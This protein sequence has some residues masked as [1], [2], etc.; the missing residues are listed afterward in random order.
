MQGSA[1]FYFS[2]L[3]GE[4]LSELVEKLPIAAFV[5]DDDRLYC[6]RAAEN[7]TGYSNSEVA[8]LTAWMEKIL[9]P[10]HGDLRELYEQDKAA[11]FPAP[12]EFMITCRD[13][14]HRLVELTAAGREQVYCVMHDVTERVR[15]EQKLR[16]NETFLRE[17]QRVGN[18]GIFDYDIVAD[19]W[20]SSREMD[21][22]F[23]IDAG[24]PKTFS[25][26][27]TILH[28]ECRAELEQYFKEIL[29]VTHCFDKEYRIIRPCDGFDRWVHGTG[30]LFY[31]AEGRPIRM[32]GTIQDIT[33]RKQAESRLQKSEVKFRRMFDVTTDAIFILAMDGSF[34]DV[35][36]AGYSRLGYTREELLAIPI[37]QLDSPEFAARVPERLKKVR[38][39]GVFV[40]E[41]AHR[42]KDGSI[43]PVEVNCRLHEHEGKQVYFSVIRDISER[44]QAEQQ[45]RESEER[46]R[47]FSNLTS[48]YVYSCRRSGNEPFRVQWIA[49]ATEE[50]TGYSL[51]ELMARGCWLSFI[52]PDDQVRFSRLLLALAPGDKCVEEFRLIRKDGSI[53]WISESCSCEQGAY[54]GELL[55]FGTSRDITARKNAEAATREVEAL[56]TMVLE[57]S[58][59]YVF[60][61]DENIRVTRLSRNYEKMLE[62]PLEQIIGKS[63]MELFPGEFA[64]KIEADSRQVLRS[65]VPLV[66]DEEFGGRTFKTFKFP[67]SLEGQPPLLAGFT[68]DVTD[69]KTAQL[70]VLALN[71]NL[72]QLVAE[73]TA[74][75]LQSNEELAGFSYAVSHELRAPIVRMQGFSAILGE[76]CKGADETAFM[77]S[78]IENA[79]RELQAVVDS[80]LMLSRLSVVELSLQPVDLSEMTARKLGLLLAEHPERSVELVVMPG[81]T[82]VVDPGLMDI[83]LN[84]LLNNAFKYTGQTLAARIEFGQLDITGEKVYFVRDN[85]AGFD[86]NYSEK[87]YAPF[88]RLH[89]HQEFSGSGIGLATVKRIINRHGGNVWAE[90]TVG[91]GATFYFTLG[92][93]G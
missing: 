66:V 28:P 30:E 64:R 70:E 59:V 69:L 5:V 41:S 91:H 52:H 79:S 47:R 77:A 18:M 45:L 48:D 32:I 22:I 82:A 43:M 67:I 86:M 56:F 92:G 46:Y 39:R 1:P 34:I 21:S 55:L 15:V 60:F 83:C 58:P 87:L 61:M 13:G 24:F 85:G 81:V 89:Q 62:M 36:W 90:S 2:R 7:L 68:V 10:V 29:A 53:R 84:N 38:E 11:G 31:D 9:E 88:Q 16:D 57:H 54:P 23:G 74:A 4:L 50:I 37:S 65:G 3:S 12:R 35:N 63:L 51:A 76:L 26:W 20:S 40:F 25:T 42:R 93:N 14:N 44:K 73:R 75:L 33:G 27:L 80:I 49:G 72:E 78:R 17:A 71:E 6:N 8:T 19:S